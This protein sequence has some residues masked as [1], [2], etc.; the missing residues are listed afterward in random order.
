MEVEAFFDSLVHANVLKGAITLWLC[1]MIIGR[2]NY[3]A[4]AFNHCVRGVDDAQWGSTV[5]C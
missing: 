3:R 5:S 2:W 4:V 1:F